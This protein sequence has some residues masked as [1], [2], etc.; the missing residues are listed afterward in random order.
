VTPH[1]LQ[2]HCS[3]AAFRARSIAEAAAAEGIGVIQITP[4][5]PACPQE[6]GDGLAS[7]LSRE[8]ITHAH[9][10]AEGDSWAAGVWAAT[11]NACRLILDVAEFP[12]WT[13]DSAIGTED[14]ERA[15]AALRMFASAASRAD[16]VIIRGEALARALYDTGLTAGADIIEDVTPVE[17]CA[18]RCG[19]A[20]GLGRGLGLDERRVIGV[21]E[22]LDDDPGL[23]EAVRAL[24]IVLER[25][26]KAV[27]LFCG[28][29]GGGQTLVRMAASLGV[30][31]RVVISE[32]L[33]PDHAAEHLSAFSVA[34]FP[35][36]RAGRVGLGSPLALQ[37]AMAAGT[38]IVAADTV[39]SRQRLSEDCARL[40]PAGSAEAAAE[41]TLELLADPA[42][43]CSLGRAARETITARCDTTRIGA[44]VTTLLRATSGRA[45][46]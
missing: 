45:A 29:G 22:T 23:I 16:G 17:F 15:R 14:S 39:W 40:V 30:G 11:R 42:T 21:Y 7:M 2:R 18:G 36:L 6:A 3:A 25:E 1:R 19:G 33:G 5:S 32:P 44:R 41:A 37:A 10:L 20:I 26:P 35:K 31:E 24:S 8:Q 27:L 13:G 12:A 4:P 38:P 46:A 43:A 28:S 9:V 34:L